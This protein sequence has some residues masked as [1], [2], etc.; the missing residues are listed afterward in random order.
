MPGDARNCRAALPTGKSSEKEKPL[1]VLPLY[2]GISVFSHVALADVGPSGLGDVVDGW[3]GW[4]QPLRFP[5]S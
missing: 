4:L 3:F 5:R 2:S 1:L